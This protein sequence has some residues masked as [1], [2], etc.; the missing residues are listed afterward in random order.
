MG[1]R[2]VAVVSSATGFASLDRRT[3]PIPRSVQV[4]RIASVARTSVHEVMAGRG[5]GVSV[6]A[7][8]VAA[9]GRK[10]VATRGGQAG[11]SVAAVRVRA[12]VRTA[13]VTETTP[14]VAR[15]VVAAEGEVTAAIAWTGRIQAEGPA[16]VTKACATTD[17]AAT[18]GR[19]NATIVGREDGT[20]AG[21]EDATSA[22]RR[23]RMIAGRAAATTG[24]T[25]ARRGNAA[26]E[27]T[28]DLHA[29]ATIGDPERCVAW[30]SSKSWSS[31]S[32]RSSSAATVSAVSKASR[33]SCRARRRAIASAFG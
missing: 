28:I 11:L 31:R 16:G 33:S 18:V 30:P 29:R 26:I 20:T 1:S 21:R 25:A 24:A 13:P 12:H 27:I 3:Q 9:T 2:G 4:L 10:V 15:E 22:G 32:R 19:G 6:A 7:T 5:R 17:D 23:D 14:A 8:V